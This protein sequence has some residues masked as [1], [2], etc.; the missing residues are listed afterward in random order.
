[1]T[2]S[3]LLLNQNTQEEISHL[4]SKN[5][6]QQTDLHLFKDVVSN[7][8]NLTLNLYSK[9]NFRSTVLEQNFE[10]LNNK[11]EPY[12]E[13]VTSFLDCGL[14]KVAKTISPITS[15]VVSA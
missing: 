3:A 2:D 5:S 15:T 8:K 6:E 14:N 10:K 12:V 13:K 11:S 4:S 1:M 9:F 7:T